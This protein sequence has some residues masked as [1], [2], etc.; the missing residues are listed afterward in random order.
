M[1]LLSKAADSV[2]KEASLA[3][4]LPLLYPLLVMELG[5][6]GLAVPALVPCLWTRFLFPRLS[7][8]MSAEHFVQGLCE[9]RLQ[10][11]FPFPFSTRNRLG[12]VSFLFFHGNLMNVDCQ[13]VTCHS[14]L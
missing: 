6:L 13:G 3:G 12:S 10:N 7:E 14:L 5:K 1:V 2:G 4:S 8:L 9:S 11:P